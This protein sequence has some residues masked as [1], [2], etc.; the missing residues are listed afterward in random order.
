MTKRKEKEKQSKTK[1]EDGIGE[2]ASCIDNG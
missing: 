1:H 2:D